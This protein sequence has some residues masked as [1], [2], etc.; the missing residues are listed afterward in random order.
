MGESRDD[1][2]VLE[3]VEQVS[4]RRLISDVPPATVTREL[5]VGGKVLSAAQR[6]LRL[7][8]LPHT[9]VFLSSSSFIHA[10]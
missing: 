10:I 7:E 5:I 1:R 8:C 9:L 4:G 3:D 6:S 2:C